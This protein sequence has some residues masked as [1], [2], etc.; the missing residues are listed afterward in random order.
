MTNGA[1]Y[2]GASYSI[3][4]GIVLSVLPISSTLLQDNYQVHLKE[5]TVAKRKE[6]PIK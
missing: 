6:E 1:N 4:L 3:V 5:K 2:K